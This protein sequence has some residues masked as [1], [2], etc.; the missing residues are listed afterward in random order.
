MSAWKEGKDWERGVYGG[1]KKGKRLTPAA[2]IASSDT[3]VFCWS[4]PE[5]STERRK[6]ISFNSTAG[7]REES[8]ESRKGEKWTKKNRDKR[9][10]GEERRTGIPLFST[11]T[12]SLLSLGIRRTHGVFLLLLGGLSTGV[13]R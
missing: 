5:D 13:L 7:S 10:E 8:V 1:G 3:P 2:L 11:E 6:R 12:L 9:S 4:A